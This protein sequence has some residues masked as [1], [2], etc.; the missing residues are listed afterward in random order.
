MGVGEGA[1]SGRPALTLT[2]ACPESARAC[3]LTS[4]FDQWRRARYRLMIRRC[5]E[6]T[7][8]FGMCLPTYDD[9]GEVIVGVSV[10]ARVHAR[11]PQRGS[12]GGGGGRGWGGGRGA[13]DVLGVG[14]AAP[15][16]CWSN[17]LVI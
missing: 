14:D 16:I 13:V 8:T 1:A 5:L 11:A 4:I 12:G 15:G 7:R 2:G 6:S 3:V 10:R 17:L 9:N